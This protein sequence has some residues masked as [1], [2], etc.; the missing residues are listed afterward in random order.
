MRHQSPDCGLFFI[1][2]LVRIVVYPESIPGTVDMKN[3]SMDMHVTPIL[4]RTLYPYVHTSR[5]NLD[6]SPPMV[7]KK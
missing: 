3:H 6:N 1:Y 7:G 5:C 2:L 4:V